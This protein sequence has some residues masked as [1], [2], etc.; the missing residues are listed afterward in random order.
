MT[1]EAPRGAWLG[2]ILQLGD[3]TVA[4]PSG[5]WSGAGSR[6]QVLVEE[7]MSAGGRALWQRGR[8]V[9]ASEYTHERVHLYGLWSDWATVR[10]T[11]LPVPQTTA[12]VITE[13]SPTEIDDDAQS[14]DITITGTGFVRGCTVEVDNSTA[15]GAT[16]FTSAVEL[17]RAVATGHASIVAPESVA[18]VVVNPDGKRSNVAILSIATP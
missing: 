2:D 8:D 17:T 13:I 16:T 11:T 15:N 18:V 5:A 6:V 3:Y 4:S 10:Q 1:T 7:A 14:H 9:G 12:P